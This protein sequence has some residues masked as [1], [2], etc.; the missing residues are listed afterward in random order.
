MLGKKVLDLDYLAKK[1]PNKSRTGL[2]INSNNVEI[3]L[4]I[5][6]PMPL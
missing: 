5:P 6:F 2:T 4:E 3:S 1:D